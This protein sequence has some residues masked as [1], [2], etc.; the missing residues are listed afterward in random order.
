MTIVK[1]DAGGIGFRTDVTKG[2]GYLFVISQDGKYGLYLFA[3]SSSVLLRGGS[4]TAI[5][6]GLNQSNLLAVVA[7]G[8]T[9]DLYVNNQKIDGVTDSTYSQGKFGVGALN[10]NSPTEV[11]FGNAKVWT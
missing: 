7:N 6:T 4:S 5:N 1:G 2:N 10:L 8:S 11:V 9:I 3:N